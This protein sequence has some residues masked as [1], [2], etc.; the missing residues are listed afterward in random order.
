MWQLHSAGRQLMVHTLLTH[1]CYHCC[2]PRQQDKR[3]EGIIQQCHHGGQKWPQACLRHELGCAIQGPCIALP[4]AGEHT[5]CSFVGGEEAEVHPAEPFSVNESAPNPKKVGGQG[6]NSAAGA[7]PRL[8][9]GLLAC[10]LRT[11]RA[12]KGNYRCGRCH[13]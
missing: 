2:Q 4:Q 7:V 6:R 5:A 8:H 1:N 10:A 3:M 11:S 9:N 13:S 12:F